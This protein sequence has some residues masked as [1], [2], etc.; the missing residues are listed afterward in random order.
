MKSKKIVNPPPTNLLENELFVP[1]INKF[2]HKLRVD[3]LNI[4]INEL[5]Y[6]MNLNN[7]KYYQ[8]IVNGYKDKDGV[9]RYKQPTIK[10]IFSGLNFAMNNFDNWKSKKEEINNLIFKY[11]IKF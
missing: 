10:Y 1:E 4:T 3:V 9:L 8:Q 7:E 5:V 11:I 2:I 6:N